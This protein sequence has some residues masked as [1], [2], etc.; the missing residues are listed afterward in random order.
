MQQLQAV[1][2]EKQGQVSVALGQSE[3]WQQT[4]QTLRVELADK[5]SQASEVDALQAQVSAVVMHLDI[6]CCLEHHQ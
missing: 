5:A 4:V 3:V 6:S 1:V 2:R